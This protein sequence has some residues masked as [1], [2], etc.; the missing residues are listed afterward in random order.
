MLS[1]IAAYL[2]VF[3]AAK[4]R[5]FPLFPNHVNPSTQTDDPFLSREA[6]P[7]SHEVYALRDI[8]P[9]PLVPD[10]ARKAVDRLRSLQV[11]KVVKK[12]SQGKGLNIRWNL[13]IPTLVT[14]PGAIPEE[15]LRALNVD[16][17]SDDESDTD[18]GTYDEHSG[19][20]SRESLAPEADE[21]PSPL[22]NDPTTSPL[23]VR[24]KKRFSLGW[25]RFMP[26]LGKPKGSKASPAELREPIATDEL[27]LHSDEQD[28]TPKLVSAGDTK[29]VVDPPPANAA[30]TPPNQ[31][32]SAP[33]ASN[34]P[35]RRELESKIIAQIVREFSSGGFFYSYDFDLTHT[36]QHK[37][38]LIVS[39]ASSGTALANLLPKEKDNGSGGVF[40]P[41][42]EGK[43][44]RGSAP[45]SPRETSAERLGATATATATGGSATPDMSRED[46]FVEPDIRVPLW[47]RV[48]RRFFWNEALLK[49]FIDVGAHAFVLP[50]MQGWVQSSTFTIPVP[51]NPLEPNVSLGNVPVDLVVISRR[52]RD[53]A[54]LRFQR[55]GIDDEG[56][57]ANFCETEMIVRAKVC[58]SPKEQRAALTTPR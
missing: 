25:G 4:H 6:G 51:P 39:R 13:P 12:R 58:P 14:G 1:L 24:A 5:P 29:A 52:S 17:E 10:L 56:H 45:S 42:P 27:L 22:P 23:D 21:T 37:R 20:V 49:D 43:F 7:S 36:L 9:I 8:H 41:T 40:P 28:E 47:R 31:P 16:A 57:V 53:R 2:L 38:N 11:K 19:R 48:D 55:R 44:A 34:P 30:P 35:Q 18:T 46:D 50:V 3:L 15:E 54:G 32:S 33:F 26:K